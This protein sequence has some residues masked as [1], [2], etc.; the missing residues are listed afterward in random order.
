MTYRQ[1][2]DELS[3]LPSVVL[4]KDVV[5]QNY[6]TNDM[7]DLHSLVLLK[8]DRHWDGFEKGDYYIQAFERL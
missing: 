3:K 7:F 4:D 1:L 8:E 5:V 6:A 2:I